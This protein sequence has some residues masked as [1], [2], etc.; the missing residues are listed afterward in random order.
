MATMLSNTY[1]SAMQTHPYGYALYEPQ[2]STIVKPGACGYIDSENGRFVPLLK[3]G[4]KIDLEDP[5]SLRAGNLT[6]YDSVVR[7]EPESQHWGPKVSTHVS[8]IKVDLKA[9]AS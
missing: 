4:K 9:K 7:E 2:S 3:K 6:V 1:R 5:A 8:G